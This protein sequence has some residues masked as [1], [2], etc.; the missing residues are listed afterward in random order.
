MKETK[1]RGAEAHFFKDTFFRQ[2][3]SL[4]R[5]VQSDAG[6]LTSVDLN[7]IRQHAI[8]SIAW[9]DATMGGV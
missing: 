7:S 3:L 5:C 6:G 9:R 8:L 2:L 1:W 4:D